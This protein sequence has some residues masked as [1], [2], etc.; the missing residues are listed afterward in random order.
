MGTASKAVVKDDQG[1]RKYFENALLNNRPRTAQVVSSDVLVL[2]NNAV[3]ING[4]DSLGVRVKG[5]LFANSGRVTFIVA[6]RGKDWQIVHLHR[7][8]MP[9]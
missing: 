2:S 6:K 1:I 5:K 9:N 7:S 4:I 8:A 3:L